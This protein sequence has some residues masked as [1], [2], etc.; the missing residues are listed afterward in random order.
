MNSHA[1]AGI[2]QIPSPLWGGDGGGGGL[3]T[4]RYTFPASPPTPSLPH[5]GGREAQS[6]APSRL[7]STEAAR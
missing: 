2:G 5:S 3:A 4:P 6:L 7:A 1:T